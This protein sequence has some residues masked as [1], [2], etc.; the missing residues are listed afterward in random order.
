M[1]LS[2]IKKIREVMHVLPYTIQA[3]DY[4]TVAMGVMTMHNIRH[5]PVLEDNRVVG[6][7]SDRDIKLGLYVASRLSEEEPPLTVGEICS[8][9][10]YLVDPDECL[11]VVALHMAQERIGSALIVKDEQIMGI[12][13]STDACRWLGSYIQSMRYA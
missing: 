13:T 11:D 9:N 1:D 3:D 12:F 6:I 10:P 7:L 5:L 4:I 2:G 8:K